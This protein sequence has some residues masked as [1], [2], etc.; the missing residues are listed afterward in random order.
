MRTSRVWILFKPKLYRDVFA[1]LFKSFAFIEVIEGSLANYGT[2]IGCEESDPIDI[3]VL[4]L[5]DEGEPDLALLPRAVPEAKLLA[6]SPTGELGMRR[7]PGES[8]WEEVRPYSLHQ[9][10]H[11]VSHS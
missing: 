4:S 3:I 9:L 10:L 11:E 2:E 5:N 1:R 6:L 7:L 8:Q